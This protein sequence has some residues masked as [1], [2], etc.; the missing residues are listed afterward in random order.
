[1]IPHRVVDPQSYETQKRSA[2]RDLLDKPVRAAG[3]VEHLHQHCPE[4]ILGRY[5]RPAPEQ[6]RIVDYAKVVDPSLR[7]TLFRH[8]RIGRKGRYRGAI[9]Y[10]R[11]SETLLSVL[12][13]PPR[14]VL[15]FLCV[16]GYRCMRDDHEV[17]V[18]HINSFLMTNVQW[19]V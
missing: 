14:A 17:L 9:S 12:I 2:L 4:P 6:A 7:G 11:T 15:L 13:S 8:S 16:Q 5:A 19:T 10:K 18:E 3:A 1:M